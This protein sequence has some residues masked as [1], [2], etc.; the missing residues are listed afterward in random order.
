MQE[1][2]NNP[3]I[4]IILPT[5]NRLY[6]IKEIFLPSLEKQIFL[7]YELIV[8]DDGSNDGTK[9]Y[10]ESEFFKDNF[11]NVS[12]RIVYIK[13]ENNLWAP[14]SRNKWLQFAKSDWVWIVE[15]DIQINDREFLEKFIDISKKIDTN[16][17]VISPKREE[18]INKW[19]YNLPK[20]NFVIVWKLSWE[21]YLDPFKEYTW[22][23]ENSHCSSF[24]KKEVYLSV[25]WQDSKTFF[26]NTF[27]DESDLYFRIIKAWYKIYYVWDILKIFHRNDFAK[28]WWQ[29]K[30]NNKSLVNQEFIVIKN[31]YLY[32]KKN[33]NFPQVRILFFILVRWIKH[34]SNLTWLKFIKNILVLLKI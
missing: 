15:D 12:K 34:F 22:F 26:W 19:Y 31:H 32:L 7:D 25:W 18:S 13:N 4:S 8:I 29:K 10:F 33:Y 27:R 6:S 28:Q 14:E 20:N 24:I 16:I 17:W 3:F 30:V 5:Y 11:K 9:E 23:I 1:N 21:I 2:I